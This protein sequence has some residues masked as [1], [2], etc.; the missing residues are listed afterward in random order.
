MTTSLLR[1]ASRRFLHRTPAFPATAPF[2]QHQRLLQVQRAF[3][4]MSKRARE[5]SPDNMDWQK[6][7]RLLPWPDAIFAVS[8]LVAFAPDDPDKPREARFKGSCHCKDVTF[9][10]LSDDV[11]DSRYCHC[12]DCHKLHGAPAHWSCTMKKTDL[13]FTGDLSRLDFYRTSDKSNKYE[14]PH[15]ISCKRCHAPICDEGRNMVGLP[16]FAVSGG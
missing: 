1:P 15:K 5:N 11:L 7:P 4:Q 14:P 8:S 2:P 12:D 10:L 13:L 16:S 3:T 9:S 6:R